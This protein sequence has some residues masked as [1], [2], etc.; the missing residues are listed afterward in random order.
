[1]ARRPHVPRFGQW[2]ANDHMPYTAVFDIARTGRGKPIN[3]NDPS[4]NPDLSGGSR[5][6]GG[7]RMFNPNDP[8]DVDAPSDMPH[9]RPGYGG[10]GG[11]GG[12]D[13]GNY[14]GGQ[15]PRTGLDPQGR[16]PGAAAAAAEGRGNSMPPSRPPP[17]AEFNRRPGNRELGSDRTATE[18]PSTSFSDSPA[19]PAGNPV[20]KP[21][22]SGLMGG[23]SPA[24]EPG[25]RNSKGEEPPSFAPATPT[26]GRGRPGNYKP[27]D[28]AP[29]KGP[30][31]LPKFGTWN[32]HDPSSGDGFT[33]IFN[34]ARN[35]RKAG[36]PGRIP[37]PGDH[38]HDQDLYGNPD[39]VKSRDS[40]KKWFCCF[41]RL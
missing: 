4:D 22:A 36:G 11:G 38:P 21:T 20:K 8:E 9:D 3:P 18:S 27:E 34:Q 6:N 32:A 35:E 30:A 25:R 26:R 29:S 14:R 15:A 31:A 40:N 12:K 16:R 33:V 41:G 37:Q 39:N 1:M 2:D 28:N 19:H 7:R 5:P 13:G 17:P 24:W 23:A 10:G